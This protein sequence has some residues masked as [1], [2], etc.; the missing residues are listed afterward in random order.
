M[1]N[2]LYALHVC[3]YTISTV[4]SFRSPRVSSEKPRTVATGKSDKSWSSLL[5]GVGTEGRLIRPSGTNAAVDTPQGKPPP[6]CFYKSASTG[7]WKERINLSDLRLGDEL[8]DCVVVQELFDGKSGPKVFCDCGVGRFAPGRGGAGGDEN[9]QGGW[10]IVNAMLRL[11]RKESAARKRAARLKKRRHFTAYV[12]RIRLDNQ[13]LEVSLSPDLV[14]MREDRKK[15]PASKLVVGQEVVGS[16]VRIEPFGVFVDVGA[17]RLGLL[18][19]QKVADLYGHYID[20]EKGLVAAGLERG[21]RVRL[22]VSSNDRQRLSLDFTDDVK[23][24]AARSDEEA[25][26]HVPARNNTPQVPARSIEV[27]PINSSEKKVS[28]EAQ[29]SASRIAFDAEKVDDDEVEEDDEDDEYDDYDEDRDI[30][31]A[32]GLG[33]Y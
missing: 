9:E 14:A 25:T 6:P 22:Q 12:S 7:S 8:V 10:K 18:H 32:L 17:N 21:A 2:L 28:L 30:E 5:L 24:D 26:Q 13:R 27:A 11:D 19:I 31:D 3:F 4:F 23:D 33:T 15:A 29:T 20:K 1:R 16:V